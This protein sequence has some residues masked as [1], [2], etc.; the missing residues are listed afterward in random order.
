MSYSFAIARAFRTTDTNVN[1]Y[2]MFMASVRGLCQRLQ[3]REFL[4]P[5]PDQK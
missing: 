5:A 1:Y 3:L 2:V 4:A